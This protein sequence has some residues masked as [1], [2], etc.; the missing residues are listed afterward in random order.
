MI[1]MGT[2]VLMTSNFHRSEL[3]L[4]E[5]GCAPIQKRPTP[6]VLIG[7]LGLG[8]TLRA[9]LD[10]LPKSAKLEVAEL[11]AVVKRW[12][13]GPLARLTQGA[14]LDPRVRVVVDDVAACIR[15]AASGAPD[16]RYDAIIVDLYEGPKNLKPGQGDPLY[17][18]S[19]LRH[20][21]AALT[22]GGVYA[23]WAEEPNRAFEERL[24][25]AGFQVE[26]SRVRSG[27]PR[28]A[29]YLATKPQ[30][31]GP[32]TRTSNTNKRANKPTRR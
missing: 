30:S 27:G 29:V 18:L 4:A 5:L 24:A 25:S 23:V 21:H 9:A 28:H 32:A 15:H 31:K 16:R 20:T 12:C 7:G 26:L 8:Y 19:I 14:A 13:E 3:A 1:R 17:G 10:R 22:P 11:N 2:R 6:R